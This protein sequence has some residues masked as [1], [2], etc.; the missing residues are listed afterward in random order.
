[1]S[2]HSVTHHHE[3]G[4]H[5][6]KFVIDDKHHE[7]HEQYITG[8]Q[9]RELGS[10][11]ADCDLFMAVPKPWDAERITNE[12]KVDLAR[13]GI[14]H[15]YHRKKHEEVPI[16]INEV[17]YEVKRGNHTVTSLKTLAGIPLANELQEL[18][19]GKLKP[20]DDN[21]TVH[22]KGCEKFF[23]TVRKGQSS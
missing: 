3:G 21:G 16:F 14:E 7:W 17:R 1:M 6:L 10:I 13:P 8:K 9:I 5:V 11:P 23:S 20:L 22:I 4:K 19:D 2:K 12:E 18:V 15:F